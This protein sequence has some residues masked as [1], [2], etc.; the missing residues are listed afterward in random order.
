MNKIAT[1]DLELVVGKIGSLTETELTEVEKKLIE[2]FTISIER[3]N[4]LKKED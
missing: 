1:L 3:R 2:T 4:D